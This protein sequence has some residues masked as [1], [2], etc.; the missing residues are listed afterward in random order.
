MIDYVMRGTTFMFVFP[1]LIHIS[2]ITICQIE[3]LFAALQFIHL[4]GIT[5]CDIKPANVMICPEGNV[6]LVDF[7]LSCFSV[8]I[9][10]AGTGTPGYMAPELSMDTTGTAC[11]I[12]SAGK[13]ILELFVPEASPSRYLHFRH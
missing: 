7:G 8:G 2:C 9:I 13:T 5:H 4:A 11:D 10:S 12:W 6:R 3:Q 1:L